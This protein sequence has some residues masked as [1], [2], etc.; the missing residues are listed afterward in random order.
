MEVLLAWILRRER[1]VYIVY[2]G[3]LPEDPTYS[4]SASHLSIIR[5]VVDPRRCAYNCLDRDLVKGNIV[6]CNVTSSLEAYYEVNRTGGVGVITAKDMSGAGSAFVTPFPSSALSPPLFQR[7]VDF[8]NSKKSPTGNLF[9]SLAIKDDGTAPNVA[10]F[11]SRGPS[12]YNILKP[13]ITAP[14][15]NILAA[16]RP[17]VS[18]SGVSNLD[19]RSVDYNF[20][21]GTSMA[22]P[23][24]TGAA[25]YVKSSHPRW[26]ASAIKS[27]L[28]TTAW[29]MKPSDAYHGG[30]G[31]LV[32]SRTPEPDT[33]RA[34]R[35]C[36]RDVTNRLRQMDLRQERIC[37]S[38]EV[39]WI[40]CGL[41]WSDSPPRRRSE[42]PT[43]VR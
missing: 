16:F 41:R 39:V 9:R 24:V 34:P 40:Q 33:S 15:A 3:S 13:D 31:I 29:K 19:H 23:H 38:G 14:G 7:V 6:V 17:I 32:R 27:A 28:M 12:V 2:M 30:F 25:A 8:I 10:P 37:K 18:P 43:H 21:L 22:C 5:Q 26:S 11:S 36:L 20:L 35:A 1:Q 4:P 42:L